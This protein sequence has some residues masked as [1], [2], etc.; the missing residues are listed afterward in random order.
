M[1]RRVWRLHRRLVHKYIGAWPHDVYVWQWFCS[2]GEIG[3]V[4]REKVV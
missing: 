2:D 4:V 1:A 3:P